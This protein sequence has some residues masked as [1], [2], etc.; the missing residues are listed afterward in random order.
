MLIFFAVEFHAAHSAREQ[1]DDCFFSD[2]VYTNTFFGFSYEIPKGWIVQK[3]DVGKAAVR[4]GISMLANGDPIMPDIAEAISTNAY[5]LLFVTKQT[6]KEISTQV[7]SLQI[8][9]LDAKSGPDLKSGED[10]L[11]LGTEFLAGT[12]LTFS[13]AAPAEQFTI[14]GRT[15]WRV[16]LDI[17]VKGV[18][19]HAVEAVTIEKGYVLLF[20]FASPDVSKLD[21]LVHTMQSIRFTDSR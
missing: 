11:K 14:E 18:I 10:F 17:T 12:G 4:L 15:F 19:S 21:E 1:P 5:Q 7:S 9:A 8:Q 13:V 20:V 16:T 6:T 2:N 3:A